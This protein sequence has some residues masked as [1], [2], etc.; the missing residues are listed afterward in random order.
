[1]LDTTTQ[2]MRRP[3]FWAGALA[4]LALAGTLAAPPAHPQA[5]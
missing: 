1:M 2:G 5:A 3:R 4:A